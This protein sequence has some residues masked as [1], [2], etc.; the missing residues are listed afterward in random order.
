MTTDIALIAAQ[1]DEA[2]Q[3]AALWERLSKAGDRAKQLARD[4]DKAKAALQREADAQAKA[5]QDA[6]FARIESLRVQ[7]TTS[8]PSAGKNLLRRSYSIT[9]TAPEFD[10][11]TQTSY[12]REHTKPGFEQ[13]PDEVYDCLIERHSEKIPAAIMALAPDS[14]REALGEYLAARRRGYVTSKAAA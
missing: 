3:D 11:Y 2:T 9:Y 10:M 1:L 14:P 4:L 13:L 6:R 5:A 7:D 12:P 8:D